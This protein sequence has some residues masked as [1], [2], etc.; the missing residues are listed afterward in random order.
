MHIDII[1]RIKIFKIKKERTS[2]LQS[3]EENG[4]VPFAGHLLVLRVFV[5]G[6]ATI[7]DSG[8][9]DIQHQGEH[10]QADGGAQEDV[11]GGE[12]LDQGQLRPIVDI[13]PVILQIKIN[14][15]RVSIA[16]D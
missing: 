3:L 9:D 15:A 16:D 11:Q 2:V 1:N 14:N 13:N 5:S 12:V 8:G 6:S 4:L 10:A 7:L